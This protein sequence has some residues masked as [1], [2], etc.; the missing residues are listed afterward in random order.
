MALG[1]GENELA[2]G[3]FDPPPSA[4]PP[5]QWSSAFLSFAHCPADLTFRGEEGAGLE[6]VLLNY[7][8]EAGTVLTLVSQSKP[9]LQVQR[10]GEGTTW[11]DV[12]CCQHLVALPGAVLQRATGGAVRA[13]KTRVDRTRAMTT[14]EGVAAA[15][16][17]GRI[18]MAFCLRAR[19]DAVL[20][21]LGWADR[22]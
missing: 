9:G 18:S 21:A 2:D 20:N 22:I 6:D 16:V 19:P 3:L 11:M 14:E 5:G 1:L 15:A 13:V 8:H 7:G 10:G 17:D 4:L 12:N